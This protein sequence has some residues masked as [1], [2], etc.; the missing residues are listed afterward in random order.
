MGRTY[1]LEIIDRVAKGGN[2]ITINS[3]TSHPPAARETRAFYIGGTTLAQY[4]H[5]DDAQDGHRT[6]DGA[7]I[8]T[9]HS[10]NTP[11]LSAII[12]K[13]DPSNWRSHGN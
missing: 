4:A 12:K 7:L 6:V 11:L 1:Y 10:K 8:N 9:H 5:N 13:V 2:S 3:T